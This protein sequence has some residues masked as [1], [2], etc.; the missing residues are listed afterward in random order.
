MNTIYY[1][2]YTEYVR[3]KKVLMVISI[4]RLER[5]YYTYGKLSAFQ[6]VKLD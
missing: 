5:Q 4:C 3:M 6:H 1:I 2:L